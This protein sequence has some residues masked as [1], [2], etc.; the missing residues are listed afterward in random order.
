MIDLVLFSPPY[1]KMAHKRHSQP[2]DR[3]DID[4]T[5]C[6]EYSDDKNNLGNLS[7]ES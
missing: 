4:Q 5:L 3:R 7:Y 2:K 6:H 1:A